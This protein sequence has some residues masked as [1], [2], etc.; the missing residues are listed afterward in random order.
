MN[1]QIIFYKNLV[2]MF[3]PVSSTSSSQIARKGTC[4]ILKIILFFDIC[5]LI[6]SSI[7]LLFS[8]LGSSVNITLRKQLL[9][10]VSTVFGTYGL[11]SGIC[12]CLACH[13]IRACRRFFL[14]PYLTFLPIVLIIMIFYLIVSFLMTTITEASLLLL[15]TSIFILF[16]WLRLLKHWFTMAKHLANDNHLKQ[17]EVESQALATAINIL[18]LSS[19]QEE[20]KSRVRR[21]SPPKYE[22]VELNLTAPPD[23]D[24][25]ATASKMFVHQYE[26]EK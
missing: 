11:I 5:C 3:D 24:I 21:D 12:T 22:T 7:L 25:S 8:S 18:H 19:G 10:Q 4:K 1:F 13:G 14:L 17:Q 23:Y 6:T 16:I 15:I 26:S 20:Q 2:R 9:L